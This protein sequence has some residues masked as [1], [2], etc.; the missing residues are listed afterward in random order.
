MKSKEY[1]EKFIA[2]VPH[3]PIEGIMFKDITPTLE[4]AEAFQNVINDL[5]EIASNY[6]FDKI[7]CAES[8]GFMFGSAL[9][10]KMHKGMVVARKPGKLPRPGASYSYELEYGKNTMVIPE[11]SIKPGEK[12]V[13]LD[14]LLATGGSAT[15]MIKMA[16]HEGGIPVLALFYI[17]LPD[18]HGDEALKKAA[19]I[20]VRTLIDFEGV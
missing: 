15:A 1:Y 18:L 11:G 17:G 3:F 6:E 13:V 19:N 14:D 4:D 10:Y 12:L 16:Q 20:D 7:I 8:R 2:T 5:A 9:A